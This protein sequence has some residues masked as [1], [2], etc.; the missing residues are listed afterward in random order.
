[1][2]AGPGSVIGITGSRGG[3]DRGGDGNGR[4]RTGEGVCCCHIG[5]PVP[6]IAGGNEG[7]MG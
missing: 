1:M 5:C 3:E 6:K 7:G 4:C 2:T